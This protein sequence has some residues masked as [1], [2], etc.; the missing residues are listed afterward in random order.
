MVLTKTSQFNRYEYMKTHFVA[1][2]MEKV[3]RFLQRG[4]WYGLVL[5]PAGASVKLRPS[6]EPIAA[7]PLALT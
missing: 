7:R 5:P 4:T 2:I 6:C 1:N 3:D